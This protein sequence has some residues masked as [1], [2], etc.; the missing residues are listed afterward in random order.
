RVVVAAVHWP[1]RTAERA[2]DFV[3]RLLARYPALDR[4]VSSEDQAG[5][6]VYLRDLDDPD[7]CN[8]FATC[9][10]ELHWLQIHF[11]PRVQAAAARL[12]AYA[13]AEAKKHQ[14]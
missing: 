11:H 6:G 2:L 5:S 14:Q 3:R 1:P 9:L 13:K 7:M 4:L 10:Y 12:L 8:P